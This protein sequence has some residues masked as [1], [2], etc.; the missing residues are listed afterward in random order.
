MPVLVQGWYRLQTNYDHWK[1]VPKADDRRAPGIAHMDQLG[2]DNVD[3]GSMFK[4]MTEAPTYNHHTD[5]TAVMEPASG[6]YRSG[7]WL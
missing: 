1:P 4:I 5:Y 3:H 2:E 7:V 6:Y